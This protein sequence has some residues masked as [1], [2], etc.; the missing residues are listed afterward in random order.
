MQPLDELKAHSRSGNRDS[1]EQDVI[2]EADK[3]GIFVVTTGLKANSSDKKVLAEI[4]LSKLSRLVG[5]G[6]N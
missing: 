3:H 4:I 2:E 5:F 1:V 6:K